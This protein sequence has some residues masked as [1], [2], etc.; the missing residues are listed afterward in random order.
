MCC[1]DKFV[2]NKK[3]IRK[4]EPLKVKSQV[5]K[6]EVIKVIKNANRN[7]NISGA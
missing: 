7:R 5:K 6:K 1:G 2:I 4:V 3:S